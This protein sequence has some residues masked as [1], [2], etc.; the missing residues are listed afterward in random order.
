MIFTILGLIALS[1]FPFIQGQADPVKV[2]VFYESLCPYSREFFVDQLAPTYESVGEI[3]LVE[4][5]AYGF[6]TE[7]ARPSGDGYTFSCQH[8]SDECYGNKLLACGQKYLEDHEVFLDFNF[9]IM[10]SDYPPSYGVQCSNQVGLSPDVLI[11]CAN[12]TEGENLLHDVGVV[13]GQQDPEVN[14][15]PWIIINDVHGTITEDEARANLKYLVCHTY[16][17]ELPE[18]CNT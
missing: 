13:Q 3:M 12:S 11:G 2:T 10:T 9:C 16:E 8:G 15:V 5:Y 4:T 7:I 1:S 6:E 14:Y 17:G 18:G